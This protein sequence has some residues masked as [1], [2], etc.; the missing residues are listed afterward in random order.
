MVSSK[1]SLVATAVAALAPLASAFDASSRSNLA[2]YWGQGP[3]QLR[4][5]HFC[6]ETSLDII[7]I[8]FI[9]YFPDMS[10]GHWPGSN[11]GN[12]CDGSYYVT[13][14]GVVTKLLSGCHQIMEDIPICQ[15]AGKKVLLS[16]GG[17]Y[18]PDQSILSKDSA[19]AFATFLWGAFGPVAEGWE[20][21]RPFGNV[22]VDGFD[23]DIEHNGGFGYATMV[24]T[25]R[26]YFNQVPERKFYL[27]AAP[28]CIIPDAQLSD[29]ILNAAFD[30]IWIQYYNTAA[31]SAKSFI[32]ST[33]GKFNFDAWVTTLKAS[34][35]KDAKLYVG[36]P[37]SETA[38]NSGYYLTPDE[39]ESLVS[40]YMDR[41]PDTFG[42]IMLWEATASE[43]N[44]I[45]GAPYA[46][47]MK[48]ILLDCDPSPPVTSSSAIPSSTP[49]TSATPSPSSSAVSS[50]TPVV[51]ETPSPS[52]SA[53][54]SSTPTPSTSPSPSSSVAP[55]SSPVSSSS[56]VASSTPVSS[57]TPVIPGT[58]ASSSPV[59]SS[60]AVA[61]STPVSSSTPVI[62]GTSDSSSAVSSSTAVGSS[63]PVSSS[64]PVI[65]GTS[66]SGSPVSSSAVASGTPASSS[67]REAV[68]SSTPLITLT[69]TVSPTPAPSSSGTSSGAV[70]QSGSSS[71]DLSS[72]TQTDV[73]TSPSQTAGPSTTATATTSSSSSSTDKSSTTVG[74]GNGNGSGN[75]SGS[76]TTTAATD[77]I[78]AAPIATSSAAATGA[79]SEPVT[80]TTVIV[81]SYIDICPTGF[82][83]VTTTYTTT[84]CPGTNTATATATVTNPPS[85]PG[86]AGSQTTAPA[87]PEG[88]T[89]TV[90]V[91]TQCAA[92]PTTVTLTLPV[93]ETGSKSTGV[94][95]APPAAVSEGSNPTQPSGAS[96][97]GG[98]GGSSEGEVP[99]PAVT[100]VST[101]TNTV[102]VVRP[103]SSRPV[104]LGTG[105]VRPSSTLAVKPSA[106][107]SGQSSGSGSHV[108]IPPSYTQEVVSP[109]ST[110]AA[111]RMTG[112]G[113][114]LVLA[115][116][117]L[118]A[119]F[120]L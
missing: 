82:T 15:A 35:S 75:G 33:L 109:L 70:G 98:A 50:S 72:S 85:G 40:T 69:L 56:A 19:V 77:S 93:T 111:S 61:S 105:T 97:T 87:V 102:T 66:A 55:S 57:S 6:K 79:S 4:L 3:D 12:Q 16:I 110:G 52:S 107:P 73:G 95:P 24:N 51:S 27:S 7:N 46:D 26:Q 39:V 67:T 14:D 108:P 48:D 13:K 120:V 81:T 29:A 76:T 92:K 42:G 71:T 5:S 37:A 104:I 53:V 22:V 2:I 88:W 113:H 106:K 38:A 47:H 25:F 94:V 49:V 10:P 65:P 116:L 34:A 114:G 118:S 74:S 64:T 60:S 103:T 89:T 68:A 78:T 17:A 43:N 36:L 54:P 83:T 63:S 112:L 90:T 31:C 99:L 11:F 23:F 119:F 41:Y 28:Q 59:S 101:S 96:P 45:D 8:G 115:V 91:C 9:N 20:G 30:F 44:K 32:D 18:P 1:F 117:A 21:P 84:Y 80:I 62:P 58:S 100:P 86:G